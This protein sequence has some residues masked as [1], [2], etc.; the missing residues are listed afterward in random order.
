DIGYNF[1][2][3]QLG[4]IYEGRYSKASTGNPTGEDGGGRVVTAGHTYQYNVGTIGVAILGDS[5]AAP[6]AEIAQQRLV[7]LLAWQAARHQ[8]DVNSTTTYRN[9]VNDFTREITN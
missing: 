9:V 8:L 4:N 6:P 1:I 7:D 3:D 2:I 5:T